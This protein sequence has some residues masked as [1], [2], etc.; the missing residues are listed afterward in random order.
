MAN[1]S[2]KSIDYDKVFYFFEINV[3]IQ[4]ISI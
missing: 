1:L 3:F 2:K 4:G